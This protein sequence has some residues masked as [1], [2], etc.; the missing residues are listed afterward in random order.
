MTER[1]AL[2]RT[3]TAEAALSAAEEPS[4][5]AEP[6]LRPLRFPAIKNLKKSFVL[7][8][9]CDMIMCVFFEFSAIGERM[10]RNARNGEDVPYR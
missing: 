5:R 8:E 2:A 10:E 3:G 4:S 6:W 1:S 7:S 9:R